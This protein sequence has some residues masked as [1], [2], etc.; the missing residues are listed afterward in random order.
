MPFTPSQPPQLAHLQQA[1]DAEY[2]TQVVLDTLAVEA[3]L[4]EEDLARKLVAVSTDGASVM[5]GAHTGVSV[6]HIP[7]VRRRPF[8]AHA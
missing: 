2:I 3:G 8:A 4:K 6:R 1:P 7:Q 5:I